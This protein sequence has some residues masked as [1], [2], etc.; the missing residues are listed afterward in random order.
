MN[1]LLP[2]LFFLLLFFQLKAQQLPYNPAKEGLH[3]KPNI[4]KTG[5]PG[6]SRE[7]Q[8][9]TFGTPPSVKSV[10]TP[11]GSG[12]ASGRYIITD[13]SNNVYIIGKY[14]NEVKLD[15]T[16][17]TGSAYKS[18]FLARYNTDGSLTSSINLID[19]P[20]ADISVES[21]EPFLTG[22]VTSGTLEDGTYDFGNQSVTITGI[23]A[24]IA[25]FNF[26]GSVNW[27]KTFDNDLSRSNHSVAPIAV[28]NDSI[29]ASFNHAEVSLLNSSGNNI[30]TY[31]FTTMEVLD[32]KVH[33]DALII[34]GQFFNEMSIDDI[35]LLSEATFETA[36][37]GSIA[38]ADGSANWAYE[39]GENPTWQSAVNKIAIA[40]DNSIIVSGGFKGGASWGDYSYG[41]TGS[42]ITHITA[43]GG[44]D[45]TF[46][47]SA[48]YYYFSRGFN[49][50]ITTT[51]SVLFAMDNSL[52]INQTDNGFN[53]HVDRPLFSEEHTGGIEAGVYKNGKIYLTGTLDNNMFLM[54]LTEDPLTIASTFQSGGSSGTFQVRSLE[55]GNSQSTLILGTLYGKADLYG[56]TLTANEA[57]VLAKKDYNNQIEWVNTIHNTNGSKGI[58][59]DLAIDKS[60]NSTVITGEATGEVT[61]NGVTYPEL[62]DNFV[63]KFTETGTVEWVIN[64]PMTETH[65]VSVDGEGSIYVSG[66]FSESVELGGTTYTPTLG[67]S[68]FIAKYNDKGQF[69]W[70][71]QLDADGV[72]L[73]SANASAQTISFSAEMIGT[74]VS[75]SGTDYPI[76]QA[77]GKNL[78][79]SLSPEGI[80]NWAF[81]YG[82]DAEP[83]DEYDYIADYCWATTI[84]VDH[85]G[86]TFVSGITGRSNIF[87]DTSLYSPFRY[88]HFSLK[89]DTNGDVN[90]ARIIKT[91]ER[92]A[93][94]YNEAGLDKNGN[95]YLYG[96]AADS[97]EFNDN[98]KFK[99]ATSGSY[100]AYVA[101]IDAAGDLAWVYYFDAGSMNTSGVAIHGE[102]AF[103]IAGKA[104]PYIEL[105]QTYN[106]YYGSSFIIGFCELEQAPVATGN[107]EVLNT[108]TTTY[109]I[110]LSTSS[111]VNWILEPTS[112]GKVLDSGNETRIAWSDSFSGEAKLSVNIDNFCGTSSARPVLTINVSGLTSGLNNKVIESLQ[113][114][115]NPVDEQLT[116][117]IKNDELKKLD[118]AIY[119]LLGKKHLLL[120]EGN[121]NANINKTYNLSNLAKGTYILLI[122]DGQ[123][124]E[125]RLIFKQ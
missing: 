62:Q 54:T 95:Y 31:Y 63:G 123:V 7:A 67:V 115:P 37:V 106:T 12:G 50:L 9:S 8:E 28:R 48:D 73:V 107:V 61:I 79:G 75:F 82:A 70:L 25:Y 87:G 42:F 69:Q 55:P 60:S 83:D 111:Q 26:D 68:G 124:S 72:Y 93:L 17:L 18:Y 27:V 94:N 11:G 103:E 40:Q 91:G 21:A 58:S 99:A 112:A 53:E 121:N 59:N 100:G 35:T 104:S 119:D 49:C 23:K 41:G 86:N 45:T 120:E 52:M 122:K 6:N 125:S 113:A 66:S 78:L 77:H 24:F 51:D 44:I 116:L 19:G 64:I 16:T 109:Q 34:G 105:D 43:Q 76:G 29:F 92:L 108:D 33:G 85:N 65:T 22:F 20:D 110:D 97:V 5:I 4:S 89:V 71:K 2:T 81:T 1:K 36:F 117:K 38:I 10:S 13:A 88:N 96:A 84:D 14:S 47:Q 101:Q 15:V 30:K 98:V 80:V 32:L 3:D 118:I 57:L 39:A 56:E 46:T 90:W 114:F 102:N 74:S